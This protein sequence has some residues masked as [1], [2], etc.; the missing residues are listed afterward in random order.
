MANPA[1]LNAV[2]AVAPTATHHHGGVPPTP[3]WAYHANMA[4]TKARYA[5]TAQIAVAAQ[6]ASCAAHRGR[7]AAV[8]RSARRRRPSRDPVQA[9]TP[10][11]NGAKSL[12]A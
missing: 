11:T 4:P 5:A 6:A 9:A 12:I 2:T 7:G 10:A 8:T 1:A 3:W